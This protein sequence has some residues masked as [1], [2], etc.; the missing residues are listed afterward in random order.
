MEICFK[1]IFAMTILKKKKLFPMKIYFSISTKIDSSYVKYEYY[2]FYSHINTPNLILNI[3]WCGIV[4]CLPFFVLF[5]SSKSTFERLNALI[6]WRYKYTRPSH[7]SISM[8]S[9]TSLCD[10]LLVASYSIFASVD[11]LFVNI[12]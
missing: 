12:N 4:S 11:S 10:P 5:I 8:K 1:V 2:N 6:K 9:A 7:P 3:Y